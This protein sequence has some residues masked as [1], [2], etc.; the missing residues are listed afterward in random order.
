V[1]THSRSREATLQY[2][3]Y[4]FEAGYLWLQTYTL[5]ICNTY[6]F[7]TATVFTRMRLSVT[8]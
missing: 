1:K 2:G 7:P 5:R 4:A 6:C 3:A 8:L